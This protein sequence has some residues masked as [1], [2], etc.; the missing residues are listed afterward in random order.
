MR[1]RVYIGLLLFFWSLHAQAVIIGNVLQ[2]PD[3]AWGTNLEAAAWIKSG[4]AWRLGA[5]CR[6][7]TNAAKLF[8]NWS[9]PTNFSYYQQ[10]FPASRGQVW[11]G[12]AWGLNPVDDRMNGENRAYL[13][14]GFFDESF[15]GLLFT[16]SP[17]QI[18]A[19]TPAGQWLPMSVAA[20]APQGT[21]YACFI[22]NFM[23]VTNAGGSARFDD[24]E[25]GLSTTNFIRFAHRDWLIYDWSWDGVNRTNMIVF[26][27]NCV[28]VDSNG[29]LHLS[30][31]NL[32]GHWWCGEVESMDW[33]G[34]GEYSWFVDSPLDMLES[35]TV[36]GLFCFDE[37]RGET[38][39]EIDI[40]VSRTLMSGGQS[41]LLYTIQPWYFPENG[42]Q[43]PM[44]LTHHETTHRFR[45]TP[46]QVHWQSYYGHT[47]EPAGPQGLIGDRL[48]ASRAV[49]T[50][51]MKCEINF[52]LGEG[53]LPPGT[54]HLELVIK[55]FQFRPLA[56]ALLLDEFD[57]NSRSNIWNEFGYSA[58][59]IEQTNGYLRI[60]PGLSWET[61]GY[62]T[63]TNLGWDRGAVEYTFSAR[64]KT[65]QVDI[66]KSGDDIA[67]ILSFCSEPEN[68]YMATNA[69]T[70]E[71]L[72]DSEEDRLTFLFFSKELLPDTWG[73]INFAGTVSNASQVFASGG[74]DLRI[75]LK[76]EEY[77]L[78]FLD[79]CSNELPI[80]VHSGSVSGPHHLSWR[81]DRG[82]WE[83]G[84]WNSDPARGSVFWDRTEVRVDLPSVT[85]SVVGM[86]DSLLSWSS[87]FY[88]TYSVWRSTNLLQGFVSATT[89][90]TATPPLNVFTNELPESGPVFYRV[91]ASDDV[92]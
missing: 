64:L 10:I 3:F 4:N 73:N 76:Q 90:L 33:M 87:A 19:A 18:T 23:Q 78:Q 7:G 49:P 85:P 21:A 54:Q 36:V 11:R 82:Y 37:Q 41:N 53:R 83:I 24:C 44:T 63:F 29:W 14:V 45:W 55:D 13:S 91:N 74:I 48:V 50:P 39:R 72:Y 58:H 46:G 68:G 56:G 6:S 1:V 70:L 59:E 60:K 89:N 52:W 12:T 35:N 32:D 66:A 86:S 5:P 84:A 81:L 34:Y 42:Y 38:Y 71:G 57:R 2:N 47:R 51:P 79:A 20:R 26:S 25:F 16:P 80:A 17:Q 31:R 9:A 28:S 65:V 67:S 15:N 43:L 30:I 62:S 77:A 40:E 61:A 88:R 92:L 8:G 75:V 27:T 69:F 22:L